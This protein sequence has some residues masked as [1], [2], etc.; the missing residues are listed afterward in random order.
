MTSILASVLVSSDSSS[1]IQVLLLSSTH[2]PLTVT[3]LF[4]SGPVNNYRP[5]TIMKLHR[6]V[7]ERG[8]LTKTE[9]RGQTQV[10]ELMVTVDLKKQTKKKSKGEMAV[11]PRGSYGDR[12]YSPTRI[13]SLTLC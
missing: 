8:V 1:Q 9:M 5:E 6:G 12:F 4:V 10:K 2:H 3:G 13:E 7:P 11:L